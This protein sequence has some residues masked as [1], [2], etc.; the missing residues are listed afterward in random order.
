MLYSHNFTTPCVFNDF[1]LQPNVDDYPLLIVC[2][3]TENDDHIRYIL[4]N[5]YGNVTRNGIESVPLQEA[6]VSPII[7]TLPNNEE[8]TD[9]N[10][11]W[12]ISINTLNQVVVFKVGD[13]DLEL[14]ISQPL[15]GSSCVPA[16]I[17]KLRSD[18]IFIVMCQDGQSYLVNISTIRLISFINLPTMIIALAYNARYSL[19]LTM[20]NSTATVTIQEALSQPLATK[21]IQLNTMVIYGSGFGPDD[22]FAYIATDR[23]IVFINVVMAL[24][25]TEQFTF[26]AS[27]PVCSQCPPLVFVNSTIALVSSNTGDNQFVTTLIQVFDLSSWPPLNVMNSPLSKRPKFYWSDNQYDVIQ[28]YIVIIDTGDKLSD[29]AIAGIVIGSLFLLFILICICICC[30]DRCRQKTVTYVRPRRHINAEQM[31][32][33]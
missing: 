27:I 15:L 29:G 10:L 3:L 30:T 7:L 8:E 22:N 17:Q 1:V 12:I 31:T 32:T 25:G 20:L 26:T 21:N 24:E 28:P 33:S 9:A 6:V 13:S 14:E 11:M 19:T 18:V 16:R 2:V 5:P 23:G 4:S